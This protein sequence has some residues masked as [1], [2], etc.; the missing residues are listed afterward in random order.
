MPPAGYSVDLSPG[1]IGATVVGR[2]ILFWWPCDGWQ[3]GTVA[4]ICAPSAS[5]F[6]HV[7]AYLRQ[8]SALRGTVGTLLDTA[9]Y[10]Q[11]WVLLSPLAPAGVE[12]SLGETA[13]RPRRPDLGIEFGLCSVTG[14][15]RS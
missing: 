11:R 9:S 2:C 15:K 8:T 12:R 5:V 6:A 14:S 4:R 13:T 10:G 7:A 3:R 1:D